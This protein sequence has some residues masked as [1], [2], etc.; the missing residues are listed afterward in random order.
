MFFTRLMGVSSK[1]FEIVCCTKLLVE[2]IDW[3]SGPL[4]CLLV[5]GLPSWAV[6]YTT[7]SKATET[8]PVVLSGSR[9]MKAIGY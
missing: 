7:V 3:G 1:H 5:Q 4:K 8:I 9:E 2:L 6:I